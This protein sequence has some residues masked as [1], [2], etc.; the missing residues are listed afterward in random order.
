VLCCAGALMKEKENIKGK[1]GHFIVFLTL[2]EGR[3]QHSS[4]E[5]LVFQA[6]E[7]LRLTRT[8][9]VSLSPSKPLSTSCRPYILQKLVAARKMDDLVREEPFHVQ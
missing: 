8:E 6:H 7:A 5:H 1:G 2:F 9:G 3:D 4:F